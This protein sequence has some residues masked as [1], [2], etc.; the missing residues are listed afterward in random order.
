M[1]NEFTTNME[2]HLGWKDKF[3]VLITG[4]INITITHK[5][6]NSPGRVESST[7]MKVIGP[8]EIFKTPTMKCIV[9]KEM[10]V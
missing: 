6:D 7:K 8:M 10:Q 9:P 2:I 3:K 5:C 4:W 1:N